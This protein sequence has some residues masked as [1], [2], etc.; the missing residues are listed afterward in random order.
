[1]PKPKTQK[2]AKPKPAKPH[3]NWRISEAAHGILFKDWILD[4]E[5]QSA[6]WIA[7][8]PSLA[9]PRNWQVSWNCRSTK[10]R[11]TPS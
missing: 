1:M 3:Y 10:S 4:N 2:S 9:S 6:C 8:W 11:Q 7:F 5:H